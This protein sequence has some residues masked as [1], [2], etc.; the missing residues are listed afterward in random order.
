M[1]DTTEPGDRGDRPRVA[2][3]RT[4]WFALL[5]VAGLAVTATLT[6]A[7]RAMLPW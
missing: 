2:W 4:G 7:L 1:R 3:R 5:Y 6:Y